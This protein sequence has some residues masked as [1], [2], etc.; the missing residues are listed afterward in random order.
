MTG[1]TRQIAR[2]FGLGR[3]TVQRIVARKTWRHVP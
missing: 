3:T 1:E 2:Q